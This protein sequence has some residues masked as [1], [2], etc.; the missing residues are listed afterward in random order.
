MHGVV[1]I[2]KEQSFI[3]C[4]GSH[5]FRRCSARRSLTASSS[6]QPLRLATLGVYNRGIIGIMENKM[7]TT[8]V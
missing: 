7:A 8:I 2:L 3:A 5:A 4:A 1:L 6:T